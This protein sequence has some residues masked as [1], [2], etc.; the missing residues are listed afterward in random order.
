MKVEFKNNQYNAAGEY[1]FPAIESKR[2]SYV[3]EIDTFMEMYLTSLG[4]EKRFLEFVLFLYRHQD[5]SGAFDYLTLPYKEIDITLRTAKSYISI[6]TK[7]RYF[8]KKIIMP[9]KKTLYRINPE[10][11]YKMEDVT[12]T[13]EYRFKKK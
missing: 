13:L 5:K 3:V 7:K 9:V 1:L 2:I 8:S 11:N 12:F 6:L 10:Y 4:I